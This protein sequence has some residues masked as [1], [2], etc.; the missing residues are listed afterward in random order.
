MAKLTIAQIDEMDRERR[1]REKEL[2]KGLSFKRF[3][4]QDRQA[5]VLDTVVYRLEFPKMQDAEEMLKLFHRVV[6][7]ISYHRRKMK[8][9]KEMV[10]I[11]GYS[12]HKAWTPYA[13]VSNKKGGRARKV[14]MHSEAAKTL[15]HIHIY[16][17]GKN[18][19][20]ISEMIWETQGKYWEK[21]Y[22]QLRYP[23]FKHFAYT[24][25]HFPNRY[26]TEQ[27]THVRVFGDV[28]LYIDSHR[29]DDDPLDIDS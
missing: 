27:S 2:N 1:S 14:F 24:A 23:E 28:G 26:V 16:L 20:T 25:R 11:I 3:T 12:E 29:I 21:H 18:S 5:P 19:R 17:S 10:A 6:G 15:P 13:K 7:M 8:N 4:S 22:P 9:G